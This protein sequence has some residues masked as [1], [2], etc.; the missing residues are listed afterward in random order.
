MS[1]KDLIGTLLPFVTVPALLAIL[2][3]IRLLD[4]TPLRH[5]N[6][7]GA[8]LAGCTAALV[9]AAVAVVLPANMKRRTRIVLL[10]VCGIVF[11]V[12]F[13]SYD[14]FTRNPPTEAT[15]G[16]YDIVAILA[17][18]FA[19]GFFGFTATLAI[20]SLMEW[21]RRLP[22]PQPEKPGS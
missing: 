22:K 10:L 3:F 13:F 11:L 15:E 2:Q 21:A 9:G 6:S 17:F 18:S 20:N 1:I 16:W 7:S 14:W 19:Y 5:W 12:S 8:T 4:L